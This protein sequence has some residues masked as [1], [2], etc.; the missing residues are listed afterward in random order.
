MTRDRYRHLARA[1]EEAERRGEISEA[2]AIFALEDLYHRALDRMA[3][4]PKTSSTFV[5]E[6]ST[7]ATQ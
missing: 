7:G 4:A 2:V 6:A 3:E 1:I 5:H